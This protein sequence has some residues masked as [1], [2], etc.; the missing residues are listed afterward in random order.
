MGTYLVSKSSNKHSIPATSG[1][2]PAV[3]AKEYMRDLVVLPFEDVKSLELRLDNTLCLGNLWNTHR[4]LALMTVLS[5]SLTLDF[6][7]QL[8]KTICAI[9]R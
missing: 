2:P 7:S 8:G 5:I 1:N 4:S 3:K 9:F 6:F